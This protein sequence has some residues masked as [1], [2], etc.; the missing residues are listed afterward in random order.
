MSSPPTASGDAPTNHGRRLDRAVW[1]FVALGVALRLARYAMDYPLWWDESFVAVNLLRR[2]FLDLLRPL[3]YGQVCP[4]LFLW[5]ELAVVRLLGFNEWTLRLFP[6][7][8]AVASVPLFAFAAGRVLP[9]V[10]PW[11]RWPS[12][13]CRTTRSATPPTSSRTPLTFSSRSPCSPSRW[14]A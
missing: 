11:P 10:P 8:C 5:A 7:L 12:S 14:T 2:G 13:A 6:L 4:V 3:D 9:G 1:G